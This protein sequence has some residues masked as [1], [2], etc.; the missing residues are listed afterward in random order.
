MHHR[1]RGIVANGQRSGFAVAPIPGRCRW[2]DAVDAENPIRPAQRATP[3]YRTSWPPDSVPGECHGPGGAGGA[4]GP[5]LCRR[6]V[7]IRSSTV[8]PRHGLPT[9]TFWARTR[10][11]CRGHGAKCSDLRCLATSHLERKTGFEPATPDLGKVMGFV[12][13]GPPGSPKCGSVHPVSSPS[14][15]SAP[16]VDRSTIAIFNEM[17]DPPP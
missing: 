4:G 5:C 3:A 11:A 17:A 8:S 15:E 12:R 10:Q 6:F 7:S 16:V 9:A 14:T 1:T 2:A 13:L